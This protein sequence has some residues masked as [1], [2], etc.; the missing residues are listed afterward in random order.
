MKD[1]CGRHEHV[2]HETDTHWRARDKAEFN[3]RLKFDVHLPLFE[4][5]ESQM[6]GWDHSVLSIKGASVG[7]HDDVM[8]PLNAQANHSLCIKCGLSYTQ[9]P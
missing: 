6:G 3:Y 4:S 5:P 8:R 1:D 2:E 9:W 7:R